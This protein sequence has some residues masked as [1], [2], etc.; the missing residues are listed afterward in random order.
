M[1]AVKLDESVFDDL[2]L[3]SGEDLISTFI[4]THKKGRE[5]AQDR[6][7]LKN[8][9]SAV[10]EVL[11]D[12]GHK[13][14]ER[15][16][17]LATARQLLD[18]LEFWEH[19]DAGLAVFVDEDGG[20]TPVSS[21]KPLEP[22]ALV[23]PVFMLRPLIA[24]IDPVSAPVLALT[25]DAVALFAATGP[26]VATVNVDLPSYDDVNWFVDRET[27]RQQHP[28]QVGTGR[29][30]HGHEPSSKADEDFARFLREV[31][32]A[33]KGFE[34]EMPLV[35]LGDDDLVSRFANHSE[36]ATVSPDNSG[37]TAPFAVEDVRRR[38]SP[39]VAQLEEE[40]VDSALA[41]AIDRL[42]EGR[43]TTDIHEALPAAATGRVGSIVMARE[44]PAVWGRLDES[45]QTVETHES[46]RPGDVDL[47]DRL[48]VW[49]RDNAATVTSRVTAVDDSSFI[50]T[51]RY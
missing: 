21:T 17:R 39:L 30:R 24:D 43:A 7:H 23:M 38:V 28:D 12:L 18:D 47:L 42:G 34:S 22:A 33:L 44:A 26:E 41:W 36:R 49:A 8:Q 20:V 5:V 35:V 45:T 11:A 10:E 40:R 3:G 2:A 32:S 37:I 13:P 27:Q 50:A 15:K 6:I 14:R 29:N 9:L 31:D 51:F 4:P 48:V 1:R 16:E 25:K 19:Q 46:H